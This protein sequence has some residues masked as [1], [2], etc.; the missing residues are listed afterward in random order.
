MWMKY[1]LS[2]TLIVPFGIVLTKNML[3]IRTYNEI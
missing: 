3:Y 1:V 2:H